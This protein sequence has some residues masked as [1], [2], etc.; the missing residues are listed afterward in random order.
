MQGFE[1]QSPWRN[2]GSASS[3]LEPEQTTKGTPS[4][5][6]SVATSE[7]G[8]SLRRTSKRATVGVF[9]RNQSCASAHEERIHDPEASGF[10]MDIVVHG[11]EG[12]VFE[13]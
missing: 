11:D 2:A 12:F 6:K 5:L 8:P 7:Q 10:G 4:F 9:D 1:T 13:N 3:L